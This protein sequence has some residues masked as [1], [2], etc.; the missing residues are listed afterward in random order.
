MALVFYAGSGSPPSW[1][2]WLTL[3]HKQI[4]YDLRM[5]SFQAGDLVKPEFLA[6]NPR[7]LVPA[8]TDGD[9]ALWESMAIAEY[10]EERWPEPTVLPGDRTDRARARRI[11]AEVQ[12]LRRAMDERSKATNDPALR[13][14]ADASLAR[15]LARLEDQAHGDFL[16]GASVSLADFAV[17]PQVALGQRLAVRAGFDPGIGPRVAEWMQRVEALPYFPHTYPPHWRT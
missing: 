16:A 12:Y 17:Y 6:V 2:V 15:E 8:I 11:A 3:E 4:E 7:G 1:L 14:T 10:L 5:L 13:A 9:F